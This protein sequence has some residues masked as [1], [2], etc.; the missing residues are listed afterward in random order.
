MEKSTDD[1]L[2]REMIGLSAER[3]I[4]TEFGA[5]AGADYGVEWPGSV[6]AVSISFERKSFSAGNA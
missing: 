1:D 2:L 5:Q 6:R 4:Y 3:L